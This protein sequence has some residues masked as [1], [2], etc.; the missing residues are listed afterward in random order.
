MKQGRKA[1]SLVGRGDHPKNNTIFF[2]SQH[3]GDKNIFF[4]LFQN[5][6]L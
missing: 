3:N 1:G 4:V 5:I 6:I 2:G